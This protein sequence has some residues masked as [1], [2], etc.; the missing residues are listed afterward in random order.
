MLTQ[1]KELS[2]LTHK[3]LLLS[4]HKQANKHLLCLVNIHAINFVSLA[5][6]NHELAR[7][8]QQLV[9]FTGAIVMAGDFNS[10]S[11]GRLQAL[12]HFKQTLRLQHVDVQ[13]A[14]HIKGFLTK[15]LDHV[16]YRGVTLDYAQALDSGK[17]SDHNPIY[18]RFKSSANANKSSS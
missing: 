12:A 7:L 13:Q 15:P 4:Y 1:H 5:R 14:Q 8:T 3:S 2:F 9:D 18:V 10:W 16:F 11:V 17:V 6:F